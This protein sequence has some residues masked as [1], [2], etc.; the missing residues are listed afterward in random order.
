MARQERPGQRGAR[1]RSA[2]VAL[3]LA[4]QRAPRRVGRLEQEEVDVARVGQ[5]A[6]DLQVAGGQ[7][8]QAE[9]R[10]ARGQVAEVRVVEQPPARGVQALGRA[11]RADPRAQPPPQLG[12]P[13]VV[14]GQ[15]CRRGRRRRRRR[16][17]A[18][19]PAAPGGRARSGR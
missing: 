16:P 15:A 19:P 14:L 18:T 5:R 2:A 11:G 12:L 6:Q 9:E 13:A 17:R 3:D 8:G 4:R 10:D 1:A 7:R